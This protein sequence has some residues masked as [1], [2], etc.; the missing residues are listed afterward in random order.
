M[1]ILATTRQNH[2]VELLV[3]GNNPEVNRESLRP[4]AIHVFQ[5]WLLFFDRVNP[6]AKIIHVP[7]VQPL[8]L[9]SVTGK[10]HLPLQQQAL[11][12]AM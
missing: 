1:T 5:L 10:T 12:F 4:D 6:L 11:I 3:C 2:S 7:T 9:E 8:I